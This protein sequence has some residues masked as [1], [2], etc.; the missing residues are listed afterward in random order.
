MPLL[1][2]AR[3]SVQ[4]SGGALEDVEVVHNGGAA[5]VEHVLALAAIAGT[6]ALPATDV[7]QGVLHRDPLA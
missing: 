2:C 7:R 3:A 6:A 4:N 5:K 1:C